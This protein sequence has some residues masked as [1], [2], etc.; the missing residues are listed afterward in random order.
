MSSLTYIRKRFIGLC[1][2]LGVLWKSVCSSE[3]QAELRKRAGRI[4]KETDMTCREHILQ[5]Q[6]KRR[7]CLQIKNSLKNK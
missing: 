6:D 1:T 7:N 2:Q 3:E 5:L 4:L